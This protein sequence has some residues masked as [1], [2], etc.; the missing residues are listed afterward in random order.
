MKKNVFN[1]AVEESNGTFRVLFAEEVKG[2]N[3]HSVRTKRIDA[4]EMAR[5][6]NKG[7]L[8]IK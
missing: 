7:R 2:L 4:R 8:V 3:Q 5:K 6:L 1:M